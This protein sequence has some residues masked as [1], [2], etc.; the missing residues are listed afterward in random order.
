MIF[1]ET[2]ISCFLIFP[3]ILKSQG[4]HLIT[5]PNSVAKDPG[6]VHLSTMITANNSGFIKTVIRVYN[7]FFS[8]DRWK[9]FDAYLQA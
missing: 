5:Y 9:Q 4:R 7:E 1:L 3:L 6:L 2:L 8:Y